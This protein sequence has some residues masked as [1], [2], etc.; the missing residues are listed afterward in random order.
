LKPL[1]G[2]FIAQLTDGI[3]SHEHPK[4]H[5]LYDPIRGEVSMKARGETPI[6][7]LN[8]LETLLAEQDYA[9]K[10]QRLAIA[11]EA[12]LGWTPE[13]CNAYSSWEEARDEFMTEHLMSEGTMPMS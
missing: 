13:E 8:N 4:G 9:A 3:S 5:V 6:E 10:I 12:E 1:L 7:A 2:D 11:M